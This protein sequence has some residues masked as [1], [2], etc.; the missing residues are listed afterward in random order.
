MLKI[1]VVLK[2]TQHNS[3]IAI[4]AGRKGSDKGHGEAPFAP[5]HEVLV[6]PWVYQLVLRVLVRLLLDVASIAL[7]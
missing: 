4:D 1:P 5:A 6:E 2:P 3:W 7:E